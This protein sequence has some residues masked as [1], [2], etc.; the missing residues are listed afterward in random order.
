MTQGEQAEALAAD[1]LKVLD[2][3]R[4]EFD[5]NV[6]TVIGVLEMVKLNLFRTELEDIDT[7]DDEE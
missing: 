7:D 2:R 1:I 6:S 5:I 3:Y 4:D